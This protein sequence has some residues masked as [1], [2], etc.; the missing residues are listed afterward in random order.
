MSPFHPRSI[1][2]LILIGFAVVL[3]PFLLAV[4]TAVV[5]VDGFADQSRTAV[6][7]VSAAT[8]QSRSVVEQLTDMQRALG[9]YTVR[10]DSE[11]MQIYLNRREDFRTSLEKLLA[12]NL[13][14]IDAAMLRS[15]AEDEAELYLSLSDAEQPALDR[16]WETA[17]NSLSSLAT[18]SR[19]VRT[20]SDRLVQAHANEANERAESLQRLLLLLAAGAAPA[21]V[22]L[23]VIFTVLITRPMQALGA[24]IRQLGARS[25]DEPISVS[26]PQDIEA[27]AGELEWLR[28][29]IQALE[30]QK[31]TFLQHISH[32]LKTPLTT[33]REGSE[34]LTESL[35]DWKP[36]DAEIAQLLR[37]NGIQ[38]QCLIEDLLQFAKAQDLALDLEFE[39]DV[40]LA[41]LIN[42]SITALSVVADAKALAIKPRLK[43]L[44]VRCDGA[45]IRTVIDNLLTN[46]IKYTPPG[47][48]I[49]VDLSVSNESAVI[50]VYDSGP[51][52]DARDRQRIFEPFRQG[53]AEYVS[54]V[55]GTGL[56]LSIARE[57]VEAHNGTIA[58]IE[59]NRGAHFRVEL[60]LAGPAKPT[61]VQ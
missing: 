36:E 18:R 57:Y 52:V 5:Q 12:L 54:S 10:G 49:D 15:L 45:K 33:I 27:L 47:G 17:I 26:G 41:V 58:L 28:C 56:G 51:G 7:N 60:P 43:L 23:A 59:S 20:E 50:D 11:Y 61:P 2:S 21:T 46:A 37:T 40:D 14:G 19:E 3:T 55:K 31:V 22:L 38:L 13:E 9:Q 1:V 8:E 24:A 6:L 44:A 29:R 4:V 32:E 53:S 16:D 48:Q 39:P 25:L 34:L 35:A 42:D 30:D